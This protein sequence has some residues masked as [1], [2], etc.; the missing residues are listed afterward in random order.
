M[1]HANS[2]M[3]SLSNPVPARE[4]CP[5]KVQCLNCGER[6][7][8]HA[9]YCSGCG[10]ALSPAPAAPRRRS[11]LGIAVLI[12]VFVLMGGVALCIDIGSD[13]DDARTVEGTFTLNKPKQ[14][15]LYELLALNE[16]K[17]FLVVSEH[18][19][20]IHVWGTAKAMAA[21][22]RF[23]ELVARLDGLSE[24]DMKSNMAR[25]RKTWSEDHTYRLSGH[26]RDH[27]YRVLDFEDV[28][29]LVDDS[30]S[31]KLIVDATRY[32]QEIV[33]DMVDALGGER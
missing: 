10:N 14:D 32:D 1:S 25:F 8:A 4:K 5:M 2:V 18:G 12:G 24:R 27:L 31:T 33:G 30:G 6:N 15:A 13:G 19:E 3:L 9:A 20:E 21:L 11:G 16:V 28:P 7:P 26:V 23:L 29:V 17:S 22:E